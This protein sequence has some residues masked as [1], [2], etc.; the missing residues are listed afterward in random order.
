M[1]DVAKLIEMMHPMR[2]PPLP[3]SLVP[4]LVVLALGCVAAAVVIAI[5]WRAR[6][7][8]G[9]RASA[10]AA[11][12]ASRALDPDERLAA[13]AA[14]LRR[15]A[16]AVAGESAARQHGAAWLE[17]LDGCFKTDYF[18]KGEGRAYG[19]ALYAHRPAADVEALDRALVALLSRL[20]PASASGTR[21]A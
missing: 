8:G 17:S 5:V 2:E 9:L 12:A 1:A 16:R 3:D 19:D 15:I 7:A 18:S 14:L 20:R 6:R 4:A 21:P 11:L 13:Q 10:A